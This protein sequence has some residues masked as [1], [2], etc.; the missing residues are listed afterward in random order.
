MKTKLEFENRTW[1]KLT[2]LVAVTASVLLLCLLAANGRAQ[3]FTDLHSF[4]A[5]S[6]SQGYIG[7]NSDGAYPFLGLL[8]SG[9][10][11]YGAAQVGG[12]SGW[13]TVFAV[14][15]DGTSFTTLY[16]F[17][18]TSG[19]QGGYGINSGGIAPNGGLIASGNTLYGTAQGGGT[20]GW[21]TVFAVNTNGTGFTTLHNFTATSGSPRWLWYKQRRS[22][23][24]CRIDFSGQHLV[25]DGAMWRQFGLGHGVC[26]QHRRHRLYEP[27]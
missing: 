19:S 2:K 27:A 1:L 11:L 10:T 13:G 24:V 3:T 5:T 20:S 26:P 22:L 4:T 15:T 8:L 18:A 21:G 7:T 23:S 6:G 12:S 16:N 14:N 17:K 25:W 9:N